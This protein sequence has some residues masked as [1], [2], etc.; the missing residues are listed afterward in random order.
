MPRNNCAIWL[1]LLAARRGAKRLTYLGYAP[2]FAPCSRPK[3]RRHMVHLFLGIALRHTARS[4]EMRLPFRPPSGWRSLL[5]CGT[6]SAASM[7]HAEA[8]FPQIGRDRLIGMQGV[9]HAHRGRTGSR[10]L[11]DL[12]RLD[13][14]CWSSSIIHL[15]IRKRPWTWRATKQRR[16]SLCD[17][18]RQN[19]EP[20]PLDGAIPS[21]R[22]RGGETPPKAIRND[23]SA[24]M[25]RDVPW[26]VRSL[27]RNSVPKEQ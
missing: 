24:G 1:V 19:A 22:W 25:R 27:R 12:G 17:P 4:W 7:H 13:P 20:V 23:G 2:L 15:Q 8:R 9:V 3:F 18:S 16:M 5:P 10:Q 21:I 26:G 14:C 11:A 6:A